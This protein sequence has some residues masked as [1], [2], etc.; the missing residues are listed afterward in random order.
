MNN[1]PLKKTIKLIEGNFSAKDGN[2]I[3]MNLYASKI[4]FHQMRNF[5]SNERF[6]K[7]D[8][9]STKRIPELIESMNM[10]TSIFQEAIN[11]NKN[12]VINSTLTIEFAD[13][14]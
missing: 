8:E 13:E 1:S 14:P 5:S 4:A 3:L 11:H 9:M 7:D 10:I 2:E 6:G 12:L